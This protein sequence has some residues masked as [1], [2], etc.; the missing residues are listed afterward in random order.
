MD[1]ILQKLS[2]FEI[3]VIK[4]EKYKHLANLYDYAWN[5]EVEDTGI[6]K[7]DAFYELIRLIE[8]KINKRN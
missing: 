2:D 3:L 7:K 8:T 1:D 5:K 4:H 6:L